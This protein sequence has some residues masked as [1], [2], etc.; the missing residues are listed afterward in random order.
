MSDHTTSQTIREVA[1]A[2]KGRFRGEILRPG[3][4]GFP[5]AK[6]IWNGMVA[7]TPGII[8]RCDNANDVQAAVL[9]SA[10]VGAP[11]AVRCGGHSLAGFSTCEGG[12]VIDLSR[13]R[14]I[15]IDESRRRA[16]AEGGC[17]LGTI[18]TATQRVGL[19]YPA[20]VVSHT[21]AAGL[22]LGGGT[23]WLTRMYGLSCDNVESV[24]LV[25]ADGSLVLATERK[26]ADLFWAL[27]GGGG[28][29]GVV[30]EFGLRLHP[31]TSVLLCTAWTLCD[32]VQPLL[33]HWRDNA[34][35]LPDELKWNISLTVAP[36]SPE[37]P[38]QLRGCPAASESIVWF[39][40]EE[41]GHRYL[42]SILKV[43]DRV[44]VSR[45]MI[46]F[47]TLQTMAD[48]DFP[49]GARYYTKSGYFY[50]LEDRSI[51]LMLA[52]LAEIPSRKNQ[53]ELAFLGGAAGRILASETA[54]GD[55]CAPFILN[56]LGHWSDPHDDAANIT[57]VRNLFRALRPH[58]KK[59]VYVNFMSGDENDR[60]SEAYHDSWNR[61]LEVKKKYDPTNFF[62]LNQNITEFSTARTSAPCGS[63]SRDA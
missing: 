8:L 34:P 36:D 11:T 52:A 33:R 5:E 58:M 15:D 1:S 7:R 46:S 26:N 10:G 3:D 16:L 63:Q 61:L 31:C 53:I 25:C 39:G 32:N 35:Q 50:V 47:L 62:R 2:L 38:Q 12:V 9:I 23:G 30:T 13:M 49:H 43:G 17:L 21:G 57:W 60:V 51:D 45:K 40:D 14:H 27:R 56:L 41:R 6:S 59:G 28:N 54:F 55:R 48:A 24:Q 44:G 4:P 19:A 42:D 22:I 29:F 20:G 18:D 37:I